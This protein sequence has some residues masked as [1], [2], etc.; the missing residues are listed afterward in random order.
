MTCGC[1]ECQ[2]CNKVCFY[3]VHIPNMEGHIEIDEQNCDGCGLCVQA[4]PCDALGLEVSKGSRIDETERRMK[5][6]F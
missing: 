2:I 6:I 3:D 5:Q 4:C 1:S